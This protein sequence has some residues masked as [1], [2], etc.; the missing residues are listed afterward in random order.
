MVQ[1]RAKEER[2]HTRIEWL[3]SWHTFSFGDYMDPHYMGFSDLRVINDDIVKPGKGFETH[4]HRNMEII[5]YVLSGTLAHKDS[6]GNGSLIQPGDV[7]R[8]S[9]GTGV[10]HSEF[11]PSDSEPVHL[12]QIWILPDQ[13][14]VAPSYE[15]VSFT[16]EQKSGRLCLIASPDG[17]EGAVRVHQNVSVYASVVPYGKELTYTLSSDRVAWVH[18]ASGAIQLNGKLL[19]AGDGAAVNAG[20]A[21][22]LE[23]INT[24]SELLLFDLRR[25][26]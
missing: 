24:E 4:G 16:P 8:M 25:P 7:Q 18:V 11:N 13:Q 14:G 23:G 20:E 21:L 15:Q 3:D 6:L 19:E 5:T 17:R 26:S 10:M 9:A 1:L 22:A 2:G 12:L